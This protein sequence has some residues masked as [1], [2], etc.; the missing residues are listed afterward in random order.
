VVR[1]SGAI[2]VAQTGPKDTGQDG[3]NGDR[4][5]TNGQHMGKEK[6]KVRSAPFM[7]SG[8]ARVNPNSP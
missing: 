4:K 7:P 8:R 1:L 3:E 5:G 2:V 6:D